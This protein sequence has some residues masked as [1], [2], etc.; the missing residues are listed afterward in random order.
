[1]PVL[2]RTWAPCG[3]T[4]TLPVSARSHEKVSGIG[5]LIVSPRRRRLSLGLGPVS[6]PQH[7]GPAGPAVSW[8]SVCSP[9]GR[10]LSGACGMR[11]PGGGHDERHYL[12]ILMILV[13]GCATRTESESQTVSLQRLTRPRSIARPYLAMWW[14]SLCCG[15]RTSTASIDGRT[16]RP[17]HNS[18]PSSQRLE[19]GH[20]ARLRSPALHGALVGQ[21]ALRAAP[22][23][24][25]RGRSPRR[26]GWCPG[27]HARARPGWY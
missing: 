12:V 23:L 15:A 18:R 26:C 5:A 8:T 27:R 2:R 1:M 21:V 6:T 14:P 4:P 17:P 9:S 11:E 13:S 22:S 16:A 24:S 3:T 7:P 25:S 20:E 10:R 19:E